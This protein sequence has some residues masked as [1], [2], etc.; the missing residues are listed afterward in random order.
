VVGIEEEGGG[1]RDVSR[2]D[3]GAD[4]AIASVEAPVGIECASSGLLGQSD[5]IF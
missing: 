4:A 1:R 2:D 3:L 5:R